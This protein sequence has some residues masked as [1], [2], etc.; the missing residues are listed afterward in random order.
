VPPVA[1]AI[2]AEMRALADAL[3][4]EMGGTAPGRAEP[5]GAKTQEKR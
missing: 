1:G 5:G 4:A 3:A 2:D